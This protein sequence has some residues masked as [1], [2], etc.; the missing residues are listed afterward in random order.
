VAGYLA[1]YRQAAELAQ[2]HS[3]PL[4]D[5]S[6]NAGLSFRQPEFAVRGRGLDRRLPAVTTDKPAA[7]TRPGTPRAGS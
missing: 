3:G 5:Q 7:S 2:I 6:G 4:T 1:G